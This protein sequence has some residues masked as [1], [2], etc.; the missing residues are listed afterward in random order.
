MQLDRPAPVN[1]IQKLTTVPG[2][3]KAQ[4]TGK[5][6][7]R[8]IQHP[9]N[10][11]F[12]PL[13]LE[14]DILTVLIIIAAL[15]NLLCHMLSQLRFI[16]VSFLVLGQRDF[17]NSGTAWHHDTDSGLDYMLALSL[18]SDGDSVAGGVDSSQWSDIWEHMPSNTSADTPPN[19]N[20]PL[21]T[22]GTS[23]S[24]VQDHG[25]TG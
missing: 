22:S 20:R 2:E 24:A 21:F 14:G 10:V 1:Q 8:E 9:V 18:Q 15:Y 7:H 6:L 17:V 23:S 13:G 19:N 3:L 25:Q 4:H 16:I 11:S 12:F 5:M